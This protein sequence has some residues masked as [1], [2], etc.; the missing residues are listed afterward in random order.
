MH[1]RKVSELCLLYKIYHRVDLTI[2]EYLNHFVA[3][4]NVRASA[5]L[6]EL[7]LMIPSCR[8]DEFSRSFLSAVVCL[9]NLLSSG[10]FSGG[11]LSSFKSD[12]D[13]CLLRA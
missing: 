4:R 8:T 3:A 6:G 9:W 7:A 1:R 11:S 10:V 12:M 2:N 13:L 5:A